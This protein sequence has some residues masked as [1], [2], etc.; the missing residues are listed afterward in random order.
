MDLERDEGIVMGD[1]G[2]ATDLVHHSHI[3]LQDVRDLDRGHGRGWESQTQVMN[4]NLD[5]PCMDWNH[6]ETHTQ[7]YYPT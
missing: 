1:E 2:L 3:N 6:L 7:D 5:D 4:Q